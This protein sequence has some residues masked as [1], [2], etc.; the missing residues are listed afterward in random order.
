VKRSGSVV[1]QRARAHAKKTRVVR[2]LGRRRGAAAPAKKAKRAVAAK[3]QAAAVPERIGVGGIE[4]GKTERAYLKRVIDSNRLSYGPVTREFE[5]LFARTHDCAEAIFCSSGTSAMHM[6]LAAL[7]EREGWND[8]DEVIVPAVTFVS[9]ANVPWHCRMRVRMVDVEARTYNLDPAKLEAAITPRT[10]AVM[11]VHLMGLPADMDPILE[12]AKRRGLKVIEDSC[13]T[14]FAKY[15]GRTV[16]SLGDV[17]CFSTY[18]AH[19]IVAGIG[20]FATT[21]DRDLAVR[22]R[23]YMNHG[24]DPAY[25]NIDV[26]VGATGDRLHDIASRRFSFVTAGHNF[27]ATELEAAIGLAQLENRAQII[28]RRGRIA[29]TLIAGLA[30][31]EDRIQLPFIPP[32]REHVFMLFPIVVRDGDGRSLVNWLEDRGIETRDLM[33]LVTQPI[34]RRLYGDLTADFPVADWIVKGGFYVGCHQYLTDA[35]VARMID[36]IREY[37]ERR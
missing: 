8:D 10:R 6:A 18:I 27:R 22:M 25:L 23:S 37:F 35:Q 1:P 17:G 30:D 3:K 9:T 26:G 12:I 14:M 4:L 2:A 36:V 13:E 29:R 11:P 31:L 34:M 21:N 5:R 16:G 19:F 24:R 33:P 28:R 7:K 32:D 20:G 15:R